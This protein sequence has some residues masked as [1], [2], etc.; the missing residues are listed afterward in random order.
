M[1]KPYRSRVDARKH[2]REANTARR[3]KPARSGLVKVLA[4]AKDTVKAALG[5]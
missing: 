1:A 2:F 4:N 5:L 3:D